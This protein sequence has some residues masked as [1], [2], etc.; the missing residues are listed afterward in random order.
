MGVG[1]LV[2][3]AACSL[4]LDSTRTTDQGATGGSGGAPTGVGGAGGDFA[5]DAGLENN[6]VAIL[7][8]DPDGSAWDRLTREDSF[9]SAEYGSLALTCYDETEECTREACNNFASCCVATE[10]C[11]ASVEASS[12]PETIDFAACAGLDVA[13]CVGG[14]SISVATFGPGAPTIGPGGL[15]PGGT[16][17]AEA[18]VVLGEPFDLA[19]T[20]VRVELD[21]TLPVGCG[22]SCLESAGVTFSTRDPRD[23]IE[24]DLGLLLSGSR[25]EINLMIGNT[26]A[27]TFDAQGDQTRWTLAVS[28]VGRVDVLRDGV[29]VASRPFDPGALRTASLLLFGRNLSEPGNRAAIRRIAVESS[30]CESPNAWDARLPVVVT[31]PAFQPVPE[32]RLGQAPSIA[33]AAQE[34]RVAFVL[35]GEVY[36]GGSSDLGSVELLLDGPALSPV[37]GHEALGVDDP[38]LVYD[39]S[40]WHLFYTAID[41]SGVSTIGH[42]VTTGDETVFTADAEPLR[43]LDGELLELE[44]PTLYRRDGLWVLI[45]RADLESGVSELHVY[46]TTALESGWARVAGG[47]LEGL[48]RVQ[49]PT[50]EITAPSLVVHN[51]AYRLHVA[52]RSGTRWRIEAFASDELLIWRPLGEALGPSE[53]GFDASGARAPDAISL[54]DRIELIYEGQNAISFELGWAAQHAPSRTAQRF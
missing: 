22:T 40:K 2:L 4:E 21:L 20:R 43:D 5:I 18:G 31:D 11:C 27:E 41:E 35:E 17:T 19:N 44:A 3:L 13:T 12:L 42:A 45:G 10:E 16:T 9:S 34:F 46:Y 7:V 53:E 47:T 39:G 49:T 8:A 28:P 25:D 54:T 6:P 33:V 48:T 50:S 36:W 51:S 24:A 1:A 30:R 29:E 23:F 15:V 37:H 14:D 32:A 38:E 52:S 26:V